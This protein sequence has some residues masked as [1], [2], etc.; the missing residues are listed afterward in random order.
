M[1]SVVEFKDIHNV[2]MIIYGKIY[3]DCTFTTYSDGTE[4]D[5]PVVTIKIRDSINPLDDRIIKHSMIVMELPV[6][7]YGKNPDVKIT[8]ENY[9][10]YWMK[11]SDF[12]SIGNNTSINTNK[13]TNKIDDST[14]KFSKHINNFS[15]FAKSVDDAN[16]DYRS[17]YNTTESIKK[18]LKSKLNNKTNKYNEF[19]N[20]LNEINIPKS[21]IES[22]KSCD[23][24]TNCYHVRGCSFKF[25]LKTFSVINKTLTFTTESKEVSVTFTL[26]EL[27]DSKNPIITEFDTTRN[28]AKNV[29]KSTIDIF[30]DIFNNKNTDKEKNL[31][32]I[33]F[34]VI[35]E[36]DIDDNLK[37][38]LS[39]IIDNLYTEWR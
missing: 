14:S 19:I 23:F 16:K 13:T 30:K 38:I 2:P 25:Y 27:R 22:I 37:E 8:T 12:M 39:S 21:I 5:I 36:N 7:E 20:E 32:N 10:N 15:K 11:L 18:N 3:N 17:Y 4:K 33:K 6:T 35:D 34:K 28:T 31:N 24:N 9:F 29:D 26:D 1:F